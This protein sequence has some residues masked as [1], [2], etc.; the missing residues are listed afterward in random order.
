MSTLLTVNRDRLCLMSTCQRIR[1]G[2]VNVFDNQ[3]CV[4]F[5]IDFFQDAL[6]AT[7]SR[8]VFQASHP[9]SPSPPMQSRLAELESSL[10][11]KRSQLDRVATMLLAR[12][13]DLE[14]ETHKAGITTE[15]EGCC[16]VAEMLH[17]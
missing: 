4:H 9:P 15:G 14:Y 7:L 5:H 8:H 3:E 13:K 2:S 1:C 6:D 11:D 17:I 16:V 10:A 12:Q